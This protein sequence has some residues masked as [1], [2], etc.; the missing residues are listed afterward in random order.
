MAKAI[1]F[2]LDGVLVD[3]KEIHFNALNLALSD[4]DPKF[5]ISQQEQSRIFEGL[6]TRS[7]LVILTQT[8]GL[9]RDKHDAVWNSKQQYSSAMFAS[10]STDKELVSLFKLIKSNNIKIGVASNSIRSTLDGCLK[11]LG[12]YDYVDYSLSNEDVKTPKPD[13]EIYFKC[14]EH[15]MTE[16]KDVVI[17]EDSNIGIAAATASG[18]KVL[19]VKNR[20][21]LNFDKVVDSI[22]YLLGSTNV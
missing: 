4:V 16:Q 11:A 1:I 2:D 14:M 10:V 8:K 20:D 17:F 22:N 9:H 6:T 15:L 19:V 5:V 12:V 7:K 18:A 3:S 13:P 21:D